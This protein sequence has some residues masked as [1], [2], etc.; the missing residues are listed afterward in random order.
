MSG[1]KPQTGLD[2]AVLMC[3]QVVPTPH[4]KDTPTNA[5]N[6]FT[7]WASLSELIEAHFAMPPCSPY[8]KGDH[9]AIY[10]DLAG[11]CRAKRLPRISTKS[12]DRQHD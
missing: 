11:R 8:C 3:G 7:R 10:E 4:S 5:R 9:I 12:K 1:G 6:V 2:G